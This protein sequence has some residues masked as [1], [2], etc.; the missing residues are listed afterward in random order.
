[1]SCG[2]RAES[3]RISLMSFP[4]RFFIV[5]RPTFVSSWGWILGQVLNAVNTCVR[6]KK[7]GAVVFVEGLL[8][9][10]LSFLHTASR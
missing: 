8:L 4:D 1:M 2:A 3:C 5:R 9:D 7:S 6:Q 10:C